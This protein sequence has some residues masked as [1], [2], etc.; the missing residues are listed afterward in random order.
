MTLQKALL[1]VAV[2]LFVVVGLDIEPNEIEGKYDLIALGLAC[3]AAST[4]A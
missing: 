4:W 2:F 1:I 3:F